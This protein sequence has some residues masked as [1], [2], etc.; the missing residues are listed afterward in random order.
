MPI[1]R[2][3]SRQLSSPSAPCSTPSLYLNS[4]PVQGQGAITSPTPTQS[5]HAYSWEAGAWKPSLSLP[6]SGCIYLSKSLPVLGPASLLVP[7]WG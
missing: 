5:W 7:Q 1:R 2:G 3:G 6:P 4:H